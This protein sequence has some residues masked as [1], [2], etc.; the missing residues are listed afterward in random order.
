MKQLTC[1]MCGSTD[2]VKKD[3]VFVCQSCGTKYSVEEAKKMMIEGPV[4]VQ[5]TVKVDTS[6]KVK[7]LYKMARRAKDDNNAELAAKYYEMITFENP[8]DWE[9]LFYFKYFKT[10]DTN[11]RDMDNSVIRLSNS[12]DSI[13]ALIC[14]GE[15]AADEKWD[16]A[17]EIIARIDSLCDSFLYWAKSHYR[18][19]SSVSGSISELDD[20]AFAI[21]ELQRKMADLLEKY[22]SEKSEQIVASY[23]KSYVQNY[24]LLDTVDRVFVNITL[25]SYSDELVEAEKRIKILEPSYIPLINNLAPIQI[26]EADR[27]KRKKCQR[28]GVIIGA[29]CGIIYVIWGLSIAHSAVAAGVAKDQSGIIVV[30]G[31]GLF[32]GL[33]WFIGA[34]VGEKAIS[35]SQKKETAESKKDDDTSESTNSDNKKAKKRTGII[36]LC[37]IIAVIVLMLVIKPFGHKIDS[38]IVGSWRSEQDSSISI[39]FKSNGDMIV[40]SSNFVN[41]SL[42]YEINN[43]NVIVTFATGDTETYGY[44]V[45]GDTLVFGSNYYTRLT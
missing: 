38:A 34:L 36:Y 13:F 29:V 28:I 14:N 18:K 6:D 3:G 7:N 27:K 32:T 10:K 41:D 11:L 16:I 44:A 9:S 43:Y 23:L 22:F 35:G 37:V 25:K 39:T 5:G 4:D 12:L 42:S 19:F 31:L 24:L 26:S 15:K 17:K 8:D 20:R 45:E 33:G 30:A 2:L 1:E 40:R 21:A